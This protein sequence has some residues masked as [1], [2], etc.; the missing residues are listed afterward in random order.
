MDEFEKG[1]EITPENVDKVKVDDGLYDFTLAKPRG[2]VHGRY[3]A[4]PYVGTV[5]WYAFNKGRN[6]RKEP[7]KVCE[8]EENAYECLVLTKITKIVEEDGTSKEKTFSIN[9]PVGVVP[10]MCTAFQTI[11]E[12]MKEE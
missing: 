5:G 11:V 1:E 10:N 12:K 2:F 8:D 9:I 6:G 4:E 7:N 3:L